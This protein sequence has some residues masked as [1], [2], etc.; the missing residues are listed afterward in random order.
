[1]ATDRT[2]KNLESRLDR[3]ALEQLRREVIDLAERL[4]RAEVRAAAAEARAEA[5]ERDAEFWWE[6]VHEL[7]RALADGDYA[8]HR[9]VGMT[10]NGELLVVK[11]PQA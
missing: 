5:A 2:L 9:C 10:K 1:M 4:E 7:D 3:L 6:Q 11:R 8:T